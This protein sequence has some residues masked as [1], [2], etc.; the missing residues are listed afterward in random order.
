MNKTREWGN[1]Q[2][3]I[4]IFYCVCILS[5]TFIR[6]MNYFNL[7]FSLFVLVLI[8][9]S[10]RLCKDRLCLLWAGFIIIYP[11]GDALLRGETGLSLFTA[12]CYS[13]PL[14]FL[15]MTDCSIDNCI[16][17]YL[18]FFK[19]FA[20]FQAFGVF[21]NKI[22][23]GLYL[24]L[25]WHIV[26]AP[27]YASDGFSS[28]RTV[29]A[30]ILCLGIGC[31][32]FE[33]E[34]EENFTKTKLHKWGCALILFLALVFTNKRS[35]LIAPIVAVV[36]IQIINSLHKPSRFLK[37][38]T[39]SIVSCIAFGMICVMCY[40]AGYENALSRVGATI[41]GV[42]NNEDVSSMRST[43]A[44]LMDS[45]RQDHKVFGI[46]WESFITRLKSTEYAGKVPNGHNVY[47]QILCEE[48]YVGIIVYLGLVIYTIAA[49]IKL[50]IS[51]RKEK[52]PELFCFAKIACYMLLVF[53]IYCY[54]G[55]A[56][57]DAEI[58]FPFFFAIKMLQIIHK[59]HPVNQRYLDM[60]F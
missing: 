42:R 24:K 18:T 22:W 43:W 59:T 41:I 15:V 34:K 44:E 11:L 58:Y 47:K 27:G 33:A 8:L 2:Y 39:I 60:Y 48:G 50:V 55:N 45:W 10:G 7:V 37:I 40:N 49:S 29:A 56:I 31:F 52:N 25:L 38:F 13:V 57:Y 1:M 14:F 54:S 26:S 32:L 30:Y 12:L 3:R 53:A 4:C 21:L 23:N 28:D 35:F 5:A 51:K 20:L 9:M 16:K 46:G 19:F 6:W 36:F 17:P